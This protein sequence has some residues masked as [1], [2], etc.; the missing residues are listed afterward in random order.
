ML[1]LAA[2][3]LAGLTAWAVTNAETP[4]MAEP[5]PATPAVR[6]EPKPINETVKRGLAFLVA[7][8]LPNGGWG[9]GEEATNMRGSGEPASIANVGDTC[10]AA[11]ALIRA[12]NTPQSGRYA[13]NVAK[14][15]AFV[16]AQVEKSS[17]TDL[18]VTDVRGTRLQSKLGTYVDTFLASLLFAEV[19]GKMGDADGDKQVVA[20]LEKV[21]GKISKNQKDDGG[22]ANAGWAPVL[23]QSIAAKGLNR[24]AQ[25]GVAVD[26]TVLARV[27]NHARANFQPAARGVGGIGGGAGGFKMEGAASVPLYAGAAN[28]AAGQ[29]AVNT[30]VQK[31]HDLKKVADDAK[32]PAEK[33]EQARDE[34]KHVAK[35]NEQARQAQANATRAVVAQLGDKQFVAG[36][37]SNGGE[38]FLSYMQISETLLVKGGKEWQDF[39][40]SMTE[41]LGRI[42]NPDGSWSGHHCITGRTFCTSAAIL[43]LLADRAPVP[44][45]KS[46][47]K[48]VEA[49]K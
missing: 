22:W 10:I 33:R 35:D 43:V 8:Q 31:E 40:K 23:A 36:F 46:A 37:G 28:A 15:V 20:C 13:A 3:G 24:A 32:A 47:E 21:V 48:V 2:G 26:G 45:T 5:V 25:N 16:R 38:E 7:Q 34:L 41:N 6:P 39:D 18:Y 1:V 11:L 44:A 42:Q 19:K 14:A 9:Q 29:D 17:A 12:G 4:P 30:R 27:E 49:K